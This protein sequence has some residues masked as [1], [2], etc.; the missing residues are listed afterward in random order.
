MAGAMGRAL[1]MAHRT[2]AQSSRGQPAE[3][4]PGVEAPREQ[5]GAVTR[6]PDLCICPGRGPRALIR[7]SQG[8][9]TPRKAEKN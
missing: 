5:R 9:L 8:F 3:P 1:S 2:R 7:V 4:G 6:P